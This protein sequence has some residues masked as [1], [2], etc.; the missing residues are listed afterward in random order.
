M[1]TRPFAGAEIA[2]GDL[3]LVGDD[4]EDAGLVLVAGPEFRQRRLPGEDEELLLRLVL[5]IGRIEAGGA[6]LD[7]KEPVAGEMLPRREG[8]RRQGSAE[9]PFTG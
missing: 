4:G 8:R 9:S 1:A 5:R 3:H 7:G 6:I 2:A